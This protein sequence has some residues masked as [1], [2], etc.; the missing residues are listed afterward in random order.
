MLFTPSGPQKSIKKM[1]LMLFMVAL[2]GFC[3]H[4]S[5][6]VRSVST[7][8]SSAQRVKNATLSFVSS[9]LIIGCR[10]PQNSAN[11]SFCLP[12]SFTCFCN[13]SLMLVFSICWKTGHDVIL[14]GLLGPMGP[15]AQ[16]RIPLV[17][18]MEL[19]SRKHRT[20]VSRMCPCTCCS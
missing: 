10:M 17:M 19:L 1:F 16:S 14:L 11:S 5:H 3:V 6:L 8:Y 12:G 20:N 15:C 9:V 2:A 13:P 4:F 18:M 7:W